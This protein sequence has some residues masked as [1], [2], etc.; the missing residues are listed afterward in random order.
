[1]RKRTP[2]AKVEEGVLYSPPTAPVRVACL[3]KYMIYIEKSQSRR[4][5]AAFVRATLAALVVLSV[6]LPVVIRAQEEPGAVTVPNFWDPKRRVERPAAGAVRVLRFVTTD[7]FPPFNFLDADGRLT[8]FNVD[9]ARAICTELGIGC[10]IQA[11]PFDNLIETVLSERADAAIAGIAITAETRSVLDFSDVYLKSPARFV[12]RRD[13]PEITFTP[14]GLKG[15]R[16]A[17]V[18][19]T[20]H[21]A[22]LAAFFPEVERKIYPTAETARQAVKNRKADAHFGD[23]LQLS[24]WLQSESAAGCCQFAGGPYLEARFFGQGFAIAVPSGAADV[25]NAINTALQSIH[26]KGI[27]AELYLRY[28]PVGFF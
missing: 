22:Y 20:A 7:D 3:R 15:K 28:F 16:L 18:A 25:R 13:T 21:E 11:R 17:V 1:V 24:F 12:V 27:Y 23:G 2:V 10:T 8:G 19:R 5:L 6:S 14:A 4:I 9:L 26:E